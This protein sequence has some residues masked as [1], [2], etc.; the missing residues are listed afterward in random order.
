[1]LSPLEWDDAQCGVLRAPMFFLSPWDP[2]PSL[3][4]RT[5]VGRLR[6]CTL[7][8]VRPALPCTSPPALRFRFG[9]LK[10]VEDA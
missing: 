5:L 6:L 7:S 1:M 4:F 8:G 10:S 2:L 3:L 9:R